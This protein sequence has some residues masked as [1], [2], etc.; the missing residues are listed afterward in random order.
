MP[1]RKQ[2]K[3]NKKD[4]IFCSLHPSLSYT[5]FA[6]SKQLDRNGTNIGYKSTLESLIKTGSRDCCKQARYQEAM[7]AV[8][9][10]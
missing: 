8:S 6:N 7:F 5:K 4:K 3:L 1:K 2:P 9:L 10:Y